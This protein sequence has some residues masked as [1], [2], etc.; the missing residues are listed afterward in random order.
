MI[1]DDPTA[2]WRERHGAERTV[3][4]LPEEGE[5]L[6]RDFAESVPGRTGH[7]TNA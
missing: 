5:A 4:V 1:Q 6:R 3:E 2:G 7:G